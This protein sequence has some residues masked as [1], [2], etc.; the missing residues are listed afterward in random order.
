MNSGSQRRKENMLNEDS[1]KQALENLVDDI[2]QSNLDNAASTLDVLGFERLLRSIEDPTKGRNRRLFIDPSEAFGTERV[3]KT[4]DH[5]AA[6]RN[7]LGR[8]DRDCALDHAEKALK[9]WQ[10]RD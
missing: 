8:S 5:I 4:G 6:C 10:A 1:I 2:K 9:R 7:A 3:H